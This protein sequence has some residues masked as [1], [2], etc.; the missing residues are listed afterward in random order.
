[1]TGIT[2]D[3]ED[4][5]ITPQGRGMLNNT[6]F[7]LM[8]NQSQIGR[9]ELQEQYNISPSLLDYIKDK[10]PGMG[11]LYNGAS[12]IPFDY[13]LPSDSKLYKLMS[14]KPSE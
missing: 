2:Q 3:I 14:T 6:G 8:M 1:M 10:P 13:R 4:V 5:L 12:L 9:A 7:I 11:L